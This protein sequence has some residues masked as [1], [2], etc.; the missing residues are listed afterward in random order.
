VVVDTA[1]DISGRITADRA[2]RD[3]QKRRRI[4]N[5]AARIG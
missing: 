4:K 5:A 3:D 1:T 2:V